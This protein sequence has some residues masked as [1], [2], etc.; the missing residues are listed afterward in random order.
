MISRK[1][2]AAIIGVLCVVRAEAASAQPRWGRERLPEVGAC[3]YENANFGGRY[4]CV[5]PGERLRSLPAGMGDRISSLRLVGAADVIVFRDSDMR[6]RSA[7]FSR[8][9]RDLRKEGW[10]DQ[11]SSIAVSGREEGRRGGV[12]PRDE[13]PREEAWRSDRAPVW[14][15]EAVPR[16]GACFY[17]DSD[18]RGEY[19]CVPRGAEYI[20]LPRGFN[21][22]ISTIRMF[23]S[24]VRIYQDRDFRGRS[25]EI[26]R[27]IRDLRGSW[28]D[29]ISSVKV[30]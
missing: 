3:F 4:F 19:F 11:I 30:F 25:R 24:G 20:A 14:G 5:R 22:S 23:G 28:K 17:R 29:D 6:G 26:R 9:L 12:R 21:D 2:V 18:F 10:N 13:R 15:H 7:R 1:A 16:A 8:D 27:D